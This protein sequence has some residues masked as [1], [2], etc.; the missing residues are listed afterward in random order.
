MDLLRAHRRFSR[1]QIW[2]VARRTS[3]LDLR[4]T[5]GFR[6]FLVRL[7][8][9]D[10]RPIEQK[11]VSQVRRWHGLTFYPAG[12][13][14][15]GSGHLT[16]K[17]A[18]PGFAIFSAWFRALEARAAGPIFHRALG[19]GSVAQE[20]RSFTQ[21]PQTTSPKYEFFDD[22]DAFLYNAM[23]RR[24]RGSGYFGAGSPLRVSRLALDA[25]IK[26]LSKQQ[27]RHPSRWRARLPKIHFQSLDVADI[28]PIPWENRGTWGQVVALGG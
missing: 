25:A 22:Y 23:A 4:A 21:T 11:A 12:A 28:P 15:D 18:A 3:E 13:E 2:H 10:L 8:R 5:L 19:R 7:R 26:R 17:V 27:G 1:T 24:T 9:L 16:G 20:V 6:P 14:R